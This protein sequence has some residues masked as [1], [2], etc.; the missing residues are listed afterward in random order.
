MCMKQSSCGWC[1]SS[2]TCVPGNKLGPFAPCKSG[3]FLYSA[4]DS[5]FSLLNHNNYT[6]SRKAIGGAQLTT[7]VDNTK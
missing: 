2:N 3:S 1:G 4:P 6:V 5:N 7:L